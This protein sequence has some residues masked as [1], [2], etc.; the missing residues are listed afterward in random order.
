MPPGFHQQ[1][2]HSQRQQQPQ[3]ARHPAA[4][5]RGHR[6]RR[7]RNQFALRNED[8]AR[9]R[10]HQHQCQPHQAIHGAIDDAVLHQQQGDL[11]IHDQ[12]RLRA[13][14]RPRIEGGAPTRA[15]LANS[16]RRSRR[17][18][19]IADQGV[20]FQVP[21]SI[22]TI[23]RAFW[24]SPRWSVLDMV[25][26]P[27]APGMPLIAS[28]ESLSATRNSGVPGWAFCSAPGMAAAIS[29]PASQAWAP[30][31]ETLPLPCAASYAAM[32]ASA[33]FFTG[34]L[35]GSWSATST[36]PAGSSVPSTS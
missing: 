21:L 10:K 32:Y 1:R 34:W 15:P 13:F 3:H 35:S 8:D 4:M 36:G 17:L 18:G 9:Y 29:R 27:C 28:S 2:G 30:K 20:Y 12:Y 31:V 25:N 22:L 19:C 5:Q 6:E 16:G 24:S 33:A 11:K 26:M 23:T 14:K 7:E